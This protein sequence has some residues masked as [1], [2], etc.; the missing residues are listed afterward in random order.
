MVLPTRLHR[1]CAALLSAVLLAGTVL[2]AVQHVCASMHAMSGAPEAMMQAAYHASEGEAHQH[3]ADAGHRPAPVA[4]GYSP[5]S[6]D[7]G[8]TVPGGHDCI[9]P[10]LDGC[11]CTV[12]SAPVDV[13]DLRTPDRDRSEDVA[14]VQPLTDRIAAPAPSSSEHPAVARESSPSPS[15]VRLHIWTATFLT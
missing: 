6:H 14:L 13:P 3:D 11:S 10:C 9:E 7:G 12:Q 1:Y 2:P 8:H 4:A 15:A 5:A